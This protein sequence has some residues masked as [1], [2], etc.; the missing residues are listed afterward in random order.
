MLSSRANGAP[1]EC[2]AIVAPVEP[3]IERGQR[4]VV[5]RRERRGL[6]GHELGIDDAQRVGE[7][8]V[9]MRSPLASTPPLSAM[10][11]RERVG[12]VRVCCR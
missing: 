3:A 10:F 1:D 5:R 6:I 2:E 11:D 8:R 12:R 9:E 4:I 7:L